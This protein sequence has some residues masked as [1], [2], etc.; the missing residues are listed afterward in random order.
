MR[1]NDCISNEFELGVL[2]WYGK[3]VA[4]GVHQQQKA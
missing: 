3:W 4:V 2:G 1:W